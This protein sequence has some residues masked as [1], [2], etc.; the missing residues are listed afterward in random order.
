MSHTFE[1]TMKTRYWCY[2]LRQEE[3]IHVH[4]RGQEDCHEAYSTRSKANI[5]RKAKVHIYMQLRQILR[6]IKRDKTKICFGGPRSPPIEVPEKMKPILEE[7]KR[8]VHDELLDA[9]THKGYP[10]TILILSRERVYLTFHT[11]MN[12]KES[13]VLREK[14]EELIHRGHIRESMSLCALLALLTPKKKR[15]W[16]VRG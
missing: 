11:W 9:T 12:P 10:A 4:L 5:R 13:E 3:H 8:V 2:P 6:G 7:L 15:S 16:H 1:E 14:V